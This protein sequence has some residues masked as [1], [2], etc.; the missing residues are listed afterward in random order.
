VVKVTKTTLSVP[1]QIRI[2]GLGVLVVGNAQVTAQGNGTPVGTVQFKD[3]N[4]NIGGP[5]PVIHGRATLIAFRP[6]GSHVTAVFTP[7]PRAPFMSST[8]N[9]VTITGHPGFGGGDTGDVGGNNGN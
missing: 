7:A 1:I 6:V 9:T 8:S 2:D 4:T 5:V 3:G